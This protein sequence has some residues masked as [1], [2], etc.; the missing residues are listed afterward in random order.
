[1][2]PPLNLSG[3]PDLGHLRPRAEGAVEHRDVVVDGL[4]DPHHLATVRS[5][6]CDAYNDPNKGY[7]DA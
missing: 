7:R 2:G 5:Q 4:G 1:M 3:S 6:K